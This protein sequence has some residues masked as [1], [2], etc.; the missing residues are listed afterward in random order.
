[1]RNS[2][3]RQIVRTAAGDLQHSMLLARSVPAR[4]SDVSRSVVSYL[5]EP[6]PSNEFNLFIRKLSRSIGDVEIITHF[7]PRN[8]SI[9]D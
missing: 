2:I 3:A 4:Y 1:M 9:H 5:A 7:L 8:S 6:A